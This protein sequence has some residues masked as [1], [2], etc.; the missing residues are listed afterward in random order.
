MPYKLFNGKT[1]IV[2]DLITKR[3]KE[4]NMPIGTGNFG[5]KIF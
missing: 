3:R 5:T 4:K 2:A 1:N